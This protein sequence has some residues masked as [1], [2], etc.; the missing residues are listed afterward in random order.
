MQSPS[1]ARLE[2]RAG[3]TP[4]RPEGRGDTGRKIRNERHGVWLAG[5]SLYRICRT[6][7]GRWQRAQRRRRDLEALASLNGRLL[8]DLGV[9]RGDVLAVLSGVV[10]SDQLKSPSEPGALD[11]DLCRATELTICPMAGEPR[12]DVAA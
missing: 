4:L 7:L 3:L 5:R 12:L 9:R 1:G 10:S 6:M 2:L 11:D 8:A